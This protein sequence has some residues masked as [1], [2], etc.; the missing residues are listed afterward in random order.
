MS[1][2]TETLHSEGF[3]LREDST[4]ITRDTVRIYS[5]TAGVRV[6]TLAAKLTA[7][8]E[9]VNYNPAGND[10]SQTIAGIFCDTYNGTTPAIGTAPGQGVILARG[11]SAVN[12]DRLDYNGLTNSQKDA[13]LNGA[14][15]S[16]KA[17][18]I[19]PRDGV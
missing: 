11:P 4:D 13:V 8:N 18:G 12:S 19:I 15:N 17:L 10:G 9:Y 3:I 14:T 1:T 16:L 7:N 5:G 6:G 2:K